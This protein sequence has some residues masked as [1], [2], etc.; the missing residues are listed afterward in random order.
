[1]I[2]LRDFLDSQETTLFSLQRAED[3]PSWEGWQLVNAD[4][5]EVH[6]LF[7]RYHGDPGSVWIDG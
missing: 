2:L 7:T 6:T 1:M 4:T 3:V 5:N